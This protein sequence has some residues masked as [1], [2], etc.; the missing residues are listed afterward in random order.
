MK[1]GAWWKRGTGFERGTEADPDFAS[2]HM[3]AARV[4]AD[5][6]MDDEARAAA[7][8]VLELDPGNREAPALLDALATSEE[9]EALHWARSQGA[10]PSVQV[11]DDEVLT[12][13]MGDLYLRQGAP[14]R[15]VALFERMA[16]AD[17]AN[18]LV[19]RRLAE[20][21]SALAGLEA[22]VGIA[23]LAPPSVPVDALAPTIVGVES[24]APAQAPQAGPARDVE[25][26][27]F[28]AWLDDR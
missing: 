16:A 21:R 2:G 13:T 28:M 14:D 9:E 23:D 12:V 10:E 5:L 26:D 3:V 24:L 25:P 1:R 20:A 4:Y 6:G 7:D 11:E 8:R 27:D 19:T 15:A 22:P 17:P 18:A